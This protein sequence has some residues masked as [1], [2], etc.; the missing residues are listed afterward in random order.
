[1]RKPSEQ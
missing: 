1:R